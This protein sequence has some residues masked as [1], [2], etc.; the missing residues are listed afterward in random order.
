MVTNLS[1]MGAVIREEKGAIVID[2]VDALKGSGSL[3]SYGDHRTCMAMA[4]A[5]L[6]AKGES[7]IDDIGCVSKSFPEFFT[8]LKGAQTI[9]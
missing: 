6:T 2:G 3:K 9:L 5:A 7:R 8:I 4:I 1:L